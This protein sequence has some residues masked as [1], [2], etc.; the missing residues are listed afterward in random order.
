MK[1]L[2]PLRFAPVYQPRPW[3]GRRL[4]TVLGRRLPDEHTKYGE[5]WEISDRPECQSIVAEG[6]YQGKTLNSLW[7]EQRSAVFGTEF[8]EH[9]AAHYPL[10]IKIL[11]AAQD[12]SIQVH[13]PA[14]VAA[15]LGGEPKTEAWYVV[16]ADPQARILAG[17]KPG[18]DR[19][20]LELALEEGRC[21]ELLKSWHPSRGQSLFL[22]SGHV[23]ALGG[24]IMVFEIQ[25]NS[26]TTYRLHDWGR[27]GPDGNPRELHLPQAL[28]CINPEVKAPEPVTSTADGELAACSSFQIRSRSVPVGST[29]GVGSAGEHLILMMAWGDAMLG[30]LALS[31]GATV[32]IPAELGDNARC[33][34]PSGPLT[35]KW[36]E[37]R[38][39]K[40]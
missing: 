22:Q 38:P 35:A 33:L 5:S 4:A 32:L 1:L 27:S 40:G 31:P 26:D 21:D 6:P 34:T 30:G 19:P 23:H 3:G 17:F 15:E 7:M 29:A 24:G 39:G 18:V 25:Q 9:P 11:D 14:E 37:I 16:Q 28:R 12:L 2:N 20:G 13:P 36:L 10:L 8:E